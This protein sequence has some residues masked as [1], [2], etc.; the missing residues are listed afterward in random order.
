MSVK[1]S[2]IMHSVVIF[3]YKYASYNIFMLVNNITGHDLIHRSQKLQ[4]NMQHKFINAYRGVS[5]WAFIERSEQPLSKTIEQ[6]SVEPEKAA[7]CKAVFCS[8]SHSWGLPPR[9]SRNLE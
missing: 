9:S 1:N 7:Q 3:S 6:I 4:K 5:P 2:K 8:T